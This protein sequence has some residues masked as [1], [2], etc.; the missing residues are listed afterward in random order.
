MTSDRYA[1]RALAMPSP[2]REQWAAPGQHSASI[3]SSKPCSSPGEGKE[4]MEV[5]ALHC[6]VTVCSSKAE[7]KAAFLEAAAKRGSGFAEATWYVKQRN[8]RKPACSSMA[9]IAVIS[10]VL[11]AEVY[12]ELLSC[13][14]QVWEA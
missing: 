10:E 13:A 9:T 4:S 3:A 14:L 7:A 6:A 12:N 8:C 2:L 11:V 5:P 1:V